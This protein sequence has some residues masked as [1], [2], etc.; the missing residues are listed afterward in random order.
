MKKIVKYT[1]LI[2]LIFYINDNLFSQED[3][4]WIE[5]DSYDIFDGEW[6]GNAVSYIKSN[7]NNTEFESLLNISMTYNYKKGDKVVSSVVKIDFSVFLTD[8]ANMDAMKKEGYTKDI[9]WEMFKNL[10]RTDFFKF[11]NYSVSYENS[12]PAVEYF[13]S[14]SEGKFLTNK[15]KDILLLIYY[16][17]RFILG[18]GDSGFT[19]MIFRKKNKIL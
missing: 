18:I 5:I 4:N 9:I 11:N 14:D 10:L 16:K 8:L 6:E 1:I 3:E 7:Y 2:I 17:P 15:N 13:A 19:K 12:S